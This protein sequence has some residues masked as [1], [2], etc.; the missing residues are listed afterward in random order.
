MKEQELLQAKSSSNPWVRV[1]DNCEMNPNNYNGG[2]DV[3][4]MR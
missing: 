2:R 3:T 1:V 4:R